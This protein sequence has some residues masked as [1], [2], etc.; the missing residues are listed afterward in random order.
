MIVVLGPGPFQFIRG[1]ET[2]SRR[3][4]KKNKKNPFSV[5][6]VFSK[7]TLRF[8]TVYA[9]YDR[10]VLHNVSI[11]RCQA[12]KILIFKLGR[13]KILTSGRKCATVS[14]R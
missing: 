4:R 2:T 5:Q 11:L 8:C 3:L 12:G 7:V 9:K 1:D 6:N 14:N 13:T 10:V